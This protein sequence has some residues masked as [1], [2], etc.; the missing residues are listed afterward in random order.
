MIDAI[1]ALGL[2]G[3]AAA[4]SAAPGPC[5]VVT[6]SR[7]ATE[8]LWSGLRVSLGSAKSLSILLG[9]TWAMIFGVW[10]I[11]D[12]T[13]QAL[14][15]AGLGMLALSMFATRSGAD[16]SAPVIARL[17]TSEW[18]IGLIVG[19]SSPWNLM[20]MFAL[21]PQFVNVGSLDIGCAAIATAAV[22]PGGML[23]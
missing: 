19:L 4:N 13:W 1:M 9:V 10:S 8:G 18:A 11:S 7:A 14:Q 3:A 5:I 23:P 15:I 6:C 12:E 16:T 2:A 20:F 17:W 22:L 21:L